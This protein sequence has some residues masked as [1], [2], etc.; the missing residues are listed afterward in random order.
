MNTAEVVDKTNMMLQSGYGKRML[1]WMEANTDG[2]TITIPIKW[3]VDE[4]YP[5]PQPEYVAMVFR[6][7]QLKNMLD[8]YMHTAVLELS[9]SL[10]RKDKE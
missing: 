8:A 2:P 7:A 1:E 3:L 9:L 10:H 6:T 4:P 5:A